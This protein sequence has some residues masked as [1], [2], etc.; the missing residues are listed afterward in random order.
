MDCSFKTSVI[1]GFWLLILVSN[2][3]IIGTGWTGL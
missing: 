2:L 3:L 1:A